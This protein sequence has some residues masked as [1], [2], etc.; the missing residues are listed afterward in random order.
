VGSHEIPHLAE[1]LM[2]ID[3]FLVME[4]QFSANDAIL[5]VTDALVDHPTHIHGYRQYYMDKWVLN[6]VHKVGKKK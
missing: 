1:E 6:K 3:V 4:S 2:S 5:E